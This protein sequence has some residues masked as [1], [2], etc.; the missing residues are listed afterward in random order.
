MLPIVSYVVQI[1]YRLLNYFKSAID[2]GGHLIRFERGSGVKIRI[3]LVLYII[4][5][6]PLLNAAFS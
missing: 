1:S 3:K 2:Y 4:T 5:I 6:Q